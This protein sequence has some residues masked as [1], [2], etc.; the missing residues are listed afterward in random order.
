MK[1]EYKELLEQR[2]AITVGNKKTEFNLLNEKKSGNLPEISNLKKSLEIEVLNNKMLLLDIKSLRQE[3]ENLSANNQ[4]LINS[5]NSVKITLEKL[6]TE[7]LYF[8]EY[9][10]KY[11]NSLKHKS[12][13]SL[14][15]LRLLEQNQENYDCMKN[16]SKFIVNEVKKREINDI[17]EYEN[18]VGFLKIFH[19]I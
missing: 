1:K 5:Y 17:L 14:I 15:D 7:N 13:S 4:T 8:K 6:R 18:T 12:R 11:V 9:F 3:I 16:N 2:R 10:Y 19:V